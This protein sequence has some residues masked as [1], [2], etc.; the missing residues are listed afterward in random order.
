MKE[1][2]LWPIGAAIF[3]VFLAVAIALMGLSHHVR[4]LPHRQQ[5][6]LYS[7]QGIYSQLE[8]PGQHI[9]TVDVDGRSFFLGCYGERK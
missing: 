5:W 9:E 6:E 4:Q 1:S 7:I 2:F 3:A 8:C